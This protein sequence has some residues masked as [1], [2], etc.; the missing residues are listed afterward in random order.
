VD[1]PGEQLSPDEIERREFPR[2]DDGFDPDAVRAYL[3]EVAATLRERS[4]GDP[5]GALGAELAAVLRSARDDV[6][7][8]R[9]RAERDAAE[10]VADA[11]REAA[12]VRALAARDAA[13]VRETAERERAE[14]RRDA[15]ARR[16]ELE[17]EL[18]A[19]RRRAEIELAEAS[20]RLERLTAAERRVRERLATAQG[21]LLAALDRPEAEAEAPA[22]PPAPPP[23]GDDADAPTDA[24]PTIDLTGT[25]REAAAPTDEV[26]PDDEDELLERMVR[27]AVGRAVRQSRGDE[28]DA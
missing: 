11:E 18:R 1:H 23:P 16:A 7:A 24:A 14:A 26:A 20:E 17:R 2:A 22:A 19:A 5:A 21:E 13:T 3:R 6:A 4:E 28:P 25:E 27:D 12:T 15:E 9:A 10:V 8:V